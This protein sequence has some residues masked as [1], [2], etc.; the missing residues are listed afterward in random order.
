MF[1]AGNDAGASYLLRCIPFTRGGNGAAA[2]GSWAEL[3]L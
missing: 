3:A 1:A 2:A